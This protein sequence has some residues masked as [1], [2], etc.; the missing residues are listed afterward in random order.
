VADIKRW[1]QLRN[2]H[3]KIGQKLQLRGGAAATGSKSTK[4][5]TH[6]VRSGDTL[7]RIAQLYKVDLKQLQKWNPGVGKH[8]KVGQKLAINSY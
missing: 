5:T 1:N 8:L 6:K 3:L 7:Y 2:N 4:A